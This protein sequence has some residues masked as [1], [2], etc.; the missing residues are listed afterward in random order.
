MNKNTVNSLLARGIDSSLA[1]ALAAKKH[2][3][4]ALKQMSRQDLLALG[5]NESQ[6]TQLHSEPRPPIPE[7][8]LLK[9]LHKNRRTC[10][11]CRDASRPIIVHH[12]S[13]WSISRSHEESNLAVLCLEHHDL[14]HTKK[15]LSQNLTEAEITSSKN[16][17]ET[18]VL[19][20]DAKSIL[21]LKYE[22]DYARWDWINVQRIF[23]LI[24][25]QGLKPT[26]PDLYT[27]LQDQCFIDGRGAL[28]PETRWQIDKSP[29]SWF[30]DFGDGFRV[31]HYLGEVVEQIL[32]SLPI[33]DITS[34]I[35][36]KGQLRSIISEGDYIAAQLPFYFKTVDEG[37]GKKDQMRKAYYRGHGVRLEY[38]FDAWHCLSSSARF[39]AMTGRKVQTVFGLVRS[40]VDDE[41][42]LLVS[43]SC[44]ASGT[45]FN[46]HDARGA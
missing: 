14:A 40:I 27:Y 36:Q 37:T 32:R 17:W 43:I 28:L 18:D 1:N 22:N 30:L 4:G 21:R 24:S 2:T 16:K 25:K 45:A 12:I 15:Q 39:D 3:L 8:R 10:C 29:R 5:L 13:E 35:P 19:K 34:Y 41:G 44:L 23:E 46:R 20:L 6:V 26:R 38:T 33:I 11:V 7:S 42:D 9:V 31:A